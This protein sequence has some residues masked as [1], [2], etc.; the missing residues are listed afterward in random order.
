MGSKV[1]LFTQWCDLCTGIYSNHVLQALVYPFKLSSEGYKHDSAA[2]G[3]SNQRFCE[4]LASTLGKCHLVEDFIQALG[5]L[6]PPKILIKVLV[7]IHFIMFL[8][9]NFINFSG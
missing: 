9:M 1:L 4:Q 3:K 2:K 6:S 7:Y 5:L 8:F